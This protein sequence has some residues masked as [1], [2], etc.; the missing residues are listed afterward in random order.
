MSRN[1]GRINGDSW[2]RNNRTCTTSGLNSANARRSLKKADGLPHQRAAR[3]G[4]AVPKQ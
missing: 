4:D 1:N 2:E 3:N